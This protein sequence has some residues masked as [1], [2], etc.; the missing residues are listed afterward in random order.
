MVNP[1]LPRTP[2]PI[3]HPRP[4]GRLG[5]RRSQ[6]LAGATPPPATV[7]VGKPCRPL[8][9][10][11]AGPPQPRIHRPPPPPPRLPAPAGRHH[12]R[13]RGAAVATHHRSPP[14]PSRLAVAGSLLGQD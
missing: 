6:V 2:A 11:L 7:A 13:G 8:P 12:A 9:P 5:A 10:R 1:I 14:P 3:R 4:V